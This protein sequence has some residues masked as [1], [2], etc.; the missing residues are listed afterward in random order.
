M[1]LAEHEA[2][3]AHDLECLGY[4]GANWTRT[5]PH[6]GQPVYDVV[7]IGG[8]QSG[9]GAAFGLLRERI[10][11]VSRLELVPLSCWKAGILKSWFRAPVSRRSQ[12][13]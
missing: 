8:G 1:T 13:F 4:Q 7:I 9:L 10:M 5:E 6:D 11:R 3:V 12:M 2:R